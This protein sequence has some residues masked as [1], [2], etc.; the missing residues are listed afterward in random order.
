MARAA[1]PTG[2]PPAAPEAS[3]EAAA[4]PSGGL[5]PKAAPS[6]ALAPPP[7][8]PRFPLFD[9]L[10]GIA[11]LGI[12]AFHVAETTGRLGFG[13]AGRAAEVAGS[14]AVIVFFGI[15]GFLLYRPYAAAH[16]WARR[17]PRTSRYARRRALRILPAYWSILT[18]L[19]L[20]PGLVGVFTGDWWRYYGY[21]QLYWNRTL[22]GGIPV[23]WTLCVEVTFYIL[24]PIWAWSVRRMPTGR[25]GRTWLVA[26]LVPLAV[27]AAGGLLIQLAASREDVSH[28]LGVSVLGQITWIA[29][30]MALAVMSVAAQ[31]GQAKVNWL[32]RLGDRSE[33]CWAGAVLAFVGL[34][35]L[36]PKGGLFGL[37]AAIETPQPI[38]RTV[39]KFV[40]EGL[41]VVLF[42]LPAVFGRRQR[43]L[44]RR[45]LAWRPVV[46]LGVISYSFYLWHL[47]VVE[48]IARG[49]LPS[50]FSAQGLN[51]LA[52]VHTA[53]TVV[54]YLISLVATG[55]LASA[56]YTLIELPF[57]RRKEKADSYPR[58]R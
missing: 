18:I 58:A 37:I 27:V 12:L 35:L 43:D 34:A 33:L 44:P 25:G 31:H 53:P 21:L 36:L 7:G 41:L 46:W 17:A 55:L 2:P 52:H 11:V 13:W 49:N 23:A 6:P 29:I 1:T 15:S 48:F 56:S 9:G 20:F 50:A 51:L 42:M 40:L 26:E 3:G 5:D 32:I 54:L 47:T 28:I 19:A 39:A 10:R 4:V 8:N 45:V 16:A 38:L 30:G 57:L 24:L 14:Q 22:A